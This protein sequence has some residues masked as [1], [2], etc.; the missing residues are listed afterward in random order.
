MHP[1]LQREILKSEF[2]RAKILFWLFLFGAGILYFEL[3]FLRLELHLESKQKFPLWFPPTYG[4]FN[5]VYAFSFASY[6]KYIIKKNGQVNPILI[7]ISAF[8]E[9]LIPTFSIYFMGS[10]MSEPVWSL[11]SPPEFL[12]FIFLILVTLRLDGKVAI[13]SG[14][15]SAIQYFLLSYFF[16]KDGSTS[17]LPFIFSQIPFYVV[18][19]N[20]IFTAG[21]LSAYVTSQIK[22]SIQSTLQK[23]DEKRQIKQLF[24]QHVSPEVVNRLLDQSEGWLGDIK[25]VCILFFDIRDFTKLSE[26]TEPTV[27]IQL[28]NRIFTVSI[29]AVNANGGIVNKF[30]G[31]GFMAVFGAPI[32]TGDDRERVIQTSL[33]IRQ[34]IQSLIESG[35]I[36]QIRIGM[37]IHS[38]EAIT[39]NVG[40]EERKEYTVIGDVVN[41][42]SRIEQLTKE[43]SVDILISEETIDSK[44]K[45]RFRFV[46]KTK[47]R[48]KENEVNLYTIN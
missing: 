22:N 42:A 7:Y 21:L 44:D 38:G 30:L 20:I 14:F 27:L 11:F 46:G 10:R 19:S 4:L 40:S 13:F 39:G 48:G 17:S 16:L 29:E 32:S 25:H 6:L 45:N 47:P 28:L 23:E 26:K 31:D 15:L 33:D 18:K 9:T 2:K 43:F 37:G 12:Y 3:F 34:K 1:Q 35:A 5:A 41:T 36:P 24:G 8:L